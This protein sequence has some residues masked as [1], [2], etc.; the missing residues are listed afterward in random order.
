MEI[1]TGSR[2]DLI[3]ML[4]DA[5]GQVDQVKKREQKMAFYNFVGNLYG[6]INVNSEENYS[7]DYKGCFRNRRN[8]VKFMKQA[9]LYEKRFCSRFYDYKDFH[10]EYL[11]DILV[12]YGEHVQSLK[13]VPC[14]DEKAWYLGKEKFFDILCGFLE[15][16]GL[17]EQ[18]KEFVSKP[19]V[20]SKIKKHPSDDFAGLTIFNPVNRDAAFLIKDPD[21]DLDTLFIYIHEFGHV[22][23]LQNI[24]G[25]PYQALNSYAYMSNYPEVFSKLLEKLFLQYLI[26]NNIMSEQAKDKYIDQFIINHDFLMSSYMFSLL[27]DK[28]YR[29]GKELIISDEQFINEMCR[30]FSNREL[31]ESLV[32]EG[33]LSLFSDHIYCYGDIMA[34]H[35]LE[36][37]KAGGLRCPEFRDF[38]RIRFQPFDPEY[39]LD[40]D[41]TP[42]NFAK[43]LKK[44]VELCKK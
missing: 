29:G 32:E 34:T 2:E 13:D 27:D 43:V 24:E 6:S 15:E 26:D 44:E 39:L 20:F 30:Y 12:E 17:L 35:L 1:I 25:D 41:Y 8:F 11:G 18:F 42:E 9:N 36:P 4:D 33:N 38:Q 5:I 40:R 3:D 7:I 28:Y 21:Y 31:I 37:V 19:R 10:R 16:Y 22:V 14:S 23:D